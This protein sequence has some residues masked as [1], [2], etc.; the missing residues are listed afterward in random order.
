VATSLA[1]P[2]ITTG[3]PE[4]TYCSL[5]YTNRWLTRSPILRFDPETQLQFAFSDHRWDVEPAFYFQDNI[6][7]GNWNVS[8]G[9]RFDHYG[10]VVSES[11]WSPRIG[12]SRY[13][14]P[15]KM[16]LHASYDRAFQTPA[17]ENL[18][19]ASSPEV[20]SLDPEVLRLPVPPSYGNYFE[21]GI[22]Q[23]LFGK[24]RLD[25]NLFRRNFSNFAD[26]DVLLDTGVSFRLLWIKRGSLAKSFASPS[27]N[28]EDFPA[29]SATRIR[30]PK[31]KAQLLAAFFLAVILRRCY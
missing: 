17:M 6:H 25:A 30:P 22:T 4:S 11:A 14:A 28:G 27:Q 23:A 29:I 18:L 2:P 5:R 19:L 3:K 9:L 1:I 8:A 13:I 31:F 15:W 26:D 10:F 16:L 24:L 20:D 7:W 21:G 12:V